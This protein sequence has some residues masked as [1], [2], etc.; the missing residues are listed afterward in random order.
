VGY[1]ERHLINVVSSPVAGV[2]LLLPLVGLLLLPGAIRRRGGRRA[3]APTV[4]GYQAEGA[5]PVLMTAP[6]SPSAAAPPAADPATIVAG[7]RRCE[8]CDAPLRATAR[9][10][11]RCGAAQGEKR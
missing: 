5:Q 8:S 1:T 4:G 9:F 6:A 2:V 7:T 10:C 3:P 11:S